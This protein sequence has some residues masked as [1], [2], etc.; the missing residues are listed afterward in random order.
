[1]RLI[2]QLVR[3]RDGV[4]SQAMDVERE[5][6]A[7]TLRDRCADVVRQDDL[8]FVVNEWSQDAQGWIASVAPILTVGNF[9]NLF[10]GAGGNGEVLQSAFDKAGDVYEGPA[11]GD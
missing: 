10:A 1:M 6:F 7:Q 3:A 2:V 8:V 9:I 11:R 4:R 5:L